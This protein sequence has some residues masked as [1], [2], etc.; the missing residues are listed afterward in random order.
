MTQTASA[1]AASTDPSSTE[2][3]PPGAG[4]TVVPVL[5]EPGEPERRR[6]TATLRTSDLLAVLGALAGSISFT[7]LLFTQLAPFDG[8]IGFIV[9][10]YA[11]FLVFYTFLVAL[12]EDW[13]TVR[14]RLAA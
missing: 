12:D 7:F 6:R 1:E 14:D 4:T 5:A 13:P 10:A 11:M 2:T 8:I 9:V 3:P